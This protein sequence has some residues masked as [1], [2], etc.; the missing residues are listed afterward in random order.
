MYLH[1]LFL[2]LTIR[3]ACLP[4]KIPGIHLTFDFSTYP[5]AWSIFAIKR[6]VLLST[7]TLYVQEYTLEKGEPSR[8][9]AFSTTRL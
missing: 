3:H 5:A 4:K 8:R 7:V 1:N 2:T 9:N 6:L